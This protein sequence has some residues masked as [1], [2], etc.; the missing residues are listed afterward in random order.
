V[1]D[2]VGQ[3]LVD[4]GQ[5]A[6]FHHQHQVGV[7]QHLGAELG[8]DVVGEVELAAGH[9]LGRP[10]SGAEAALESTDRGHLG[11]D[12]SL[13]ERTTGQVLGH[14]RPATVGRAHEHQAER[15]C[16]PDGL[17]RSILRGGAHGVILP[18]CCAGSVALLF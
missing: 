4:V 1:V 10:G 15:L 18:C 7:V 16:R 6:A 8:A 13:L 14:R 3:S 9:R 2:G 11:R 12:M 17:G 5:V